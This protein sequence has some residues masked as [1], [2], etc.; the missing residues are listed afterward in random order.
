MSDRRCDALSMAISELLD[1]ERRVQ[2]KR[3][4]DLGMGP[5]TL[6]KS[7]DG[8]TSRTATYAKLADAL[9]VRIV[10]GLKRLA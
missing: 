8:H 7:L 6:S 3:Y 5:T 2:G 4:R 10:V 9:G 1:K